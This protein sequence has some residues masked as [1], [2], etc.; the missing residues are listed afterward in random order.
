MSSVTDLESGQGPQGPHAGALLSFLSLSPR[1]EVL[2]DHEEGAGGSDLALPVRGAQ[3]QPIVPHT[4][5]LDGPPS[6]ACSSIPSGVFPSASIRSGSNIGHSPRDVSD[7][8]GDQPTQATLDEPS[9]SAW[10]SIPSGAF[11]PSVS[12]R[13]GSNI[14]YSLPNFSDTTGDQVGQP[15]SQTE[16][17]ICAYP[18][19][20]RDIIVLTDTPITANHSTL[21]TLSSQHNLRPPVSTKP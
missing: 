14:D 13:S 9:F 4:E 10:G 8:A 21:L 12:I 17:Q 7:T 18:H 1:P 2:I 20:C 3:P 15:L 11:R 6:S 19:N 16:S 5:T